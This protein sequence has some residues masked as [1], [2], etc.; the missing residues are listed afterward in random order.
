VAARAF[1]K[2]VWSRGIGAAIVSALCGVTLIV[3][4]LKLVGE[5]V[6]AIP[7]VT[8]V[9]AG[10]ERAN[11]SVSPTAPVAQLQTV[12]APRPRVPIASAASL[13]PADGGEGAQPLSI[14]RPSLPLLDEP[15]VVTASGLPPASDFHAVEMLPSPAVDTPQPPPV[16]ESSATPPAA[17]AEDIRTPWAVA[18]EQGTALGRKSKDAGVAT[19]GAFTRFARKLAG[20]F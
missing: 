1:I 19:A 4:D 16:P 11:P 6:I 2:P 7:H 3:G 10:S 5:T 15:L 14:E 13:Q 17:T 20:S 12:S 8:V 18:T 9:R